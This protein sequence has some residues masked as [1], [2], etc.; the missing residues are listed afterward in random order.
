MPPRA[1]SPI[2]SAHSAVRA[3]LCVACD[4]EMFARRDYAFCFCFIRT[5][6]AKLRGRTRGGHIEGYPP[7]IAS[8]QSGTET[9]SFWHGPTCGIIHT[10]TS[11][12]SKRRTR[13]TDAQ[14]ADLCSAQCFGFLSYSKGRKEGGILGD[15]AMEEGR[16]EELEGVW[17]VFTY[18]D[19]LTH[20]GSRLMAGL[21]RKKRRRVPSR[22]CVY[23]QVALASG[24][25]PSLAS[26]IIDALK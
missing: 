18:A 10:N 19:A 7:P 21:I 24:F 1:R 16:E 8:P 26:H 9:E 6:S 15:N 14:R 11:Q 17:F 3:A 25:P 23:G 13:R 5:T 2:S 12:D 22:V 20:T 4:Q